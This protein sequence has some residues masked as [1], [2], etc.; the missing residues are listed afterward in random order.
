MELRP[1]GVGVS[2]IEP[3]ALATQL[4][5]KSAQVVKQEGFAGTATE[6]ALYESAIAHMQE[7]MGKQKPTP[8]GAAADVIVRALTT[9]KPKARYRVG[10]QARYV[11]PLLRRFPVG[12]RDRMI[13]S[14]LGL[15]AGRRE[16]ERRAV[17]PG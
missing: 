14:S 2:Y 1:Q 10:S 13:M 6:L 3:G 15:N 16:A 4:F 12:L 11:L 5:V 8:V 9:S 17:S 7:A